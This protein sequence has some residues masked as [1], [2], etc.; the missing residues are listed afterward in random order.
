MPAFQGFGPATV[1][2][3]GSCDFAA[4][5]RPGF[6]QEAAAV[7]AKAAPLMAF[8]CAALVERAVLRGRN[9]CLAV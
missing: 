2:F 9:D 1:R 5:A 4:A 3:I 8:L 7:F 6:P